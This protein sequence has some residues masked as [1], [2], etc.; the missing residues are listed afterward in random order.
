MKQKIR[1]VVISGEWDS[2]FV[3]RL[4]NEVEKSDCDSVEIENSGL[5]NDTTIR[6]IKEYLAARKIQCVLD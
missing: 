1:L 6:D 2:A 4:T 3:S 5:L